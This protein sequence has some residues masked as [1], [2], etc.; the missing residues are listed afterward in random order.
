MVSQGQ[1]LHMSQQVLDGI[2]VGVGQLK[3]WDMGLDVHQDLSLR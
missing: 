2:D 1:S 3:T